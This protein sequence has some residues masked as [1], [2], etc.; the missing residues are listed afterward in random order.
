MAAQFAGFCEQWRKRWHD[1]NSK[2]KLVEV[3]ETKG[4]PR[5][6]VLAV[7][8][9]DSLTDPVF[10]DDHDFVEIMNTVGNRWP[11]EGIRAEQGTFKRSWGRSRWLALEQERPGT[12]AVLVPHYDLRKAVEFW[13]RN[14][15][16]KQELEALGF[17]NVLVKRFPIRR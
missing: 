3:K 17:K 12:I 10:I 2:G 15:Q 5:N 1:Y 7:F 13:V 6:R 14:E 9:V 16:T 4:K 11:Y 8:T